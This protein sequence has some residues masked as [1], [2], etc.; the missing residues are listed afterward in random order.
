MGTYIEYV[1]YK[2]GNK[3]FAY[4]SLD[5]VEKDYRYLKQSS[6]VP[7]RV[8]KREIKETEMDMEV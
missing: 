6:G 1:I 5:E 2:D 3:Y 7:I 4:T 8:V